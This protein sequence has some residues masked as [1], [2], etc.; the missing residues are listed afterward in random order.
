VT[1]VGNLIA[2][3]NSHPVAIASGILVLAVAA[4]IVG[5]VALY[6]FM[7]VLI[8]LVGAVWTEEFLEWVS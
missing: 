1:G 6:A 7:I 5:R 2:A 8:V 4:R 3:L